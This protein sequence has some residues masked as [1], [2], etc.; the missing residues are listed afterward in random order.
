VLY[1]PSVFSRPFVPWPGQCKLRSGPI[2]GP[3]VR[4]DFRVSKGPALF[5]RLGDGADSGTRRAALY[6]DEFDVDAGSPGQCPQ[7]AGIGGEDVPRPTGQRRQD[8]L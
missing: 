6:G 2:G 3:T 7:T 8:P 5:A 4:A 1:L